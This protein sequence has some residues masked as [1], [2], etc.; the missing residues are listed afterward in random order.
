MLLSFS[1]SDRQE[2]VLHPIVLPEPCGPVQVA[3]IELV[4]RRVVGRQRVGRDRLRRD[5]LVVQEALQKSE[6]RLYVP[7]ALD[8]KVQN[9]AFVVH[10]PP[11]KGTSACR[12]SSR[13]SRP[14]ASA[15]RLHTAASSAAWRS[16]RPNMM[17]HHRMVS[18]L[19][20]IP[21]RASSSPDVPQTEAE[22]TVQAHGVAD[23]V[24]WKPVTFDE[25]SFTIIHTRQRLTPRLPETFYRLPDSTGAPA[26]ASP[27][28][29]ADGRG[30]G[31]YGLSMP[32]SGICEGLRWF[33]PSRSDAA[34]TARS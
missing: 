21:R 26:S 22:P 32:S 6:R 5:R 10:R 8:H 2:G 33:K 11:A 23:H 24:R 28:S 19:T 29:L 27:M 16:G 1:S 4:E 12:R 3:Q 9:F 30:S 18:Q 31:V 20:W 17:V 14:D 25:I 7:P 34:W 13:P 15:A